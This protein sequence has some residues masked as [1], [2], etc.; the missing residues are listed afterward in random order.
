IKNLRYQLGLAWTNDIPEY[1]ALYNS[2]QNGLWDFEEPFTDNNDNGV[3]DDGEPYTD[4]YSI[5]NERLE[6]KF[7][8]AFTIPALFNYKFSDR[9]STDLKYEFQRLKKGTSYRNTLL[10]DEVFFDLDGDGVWDA[11]E[12]FTDLDGDGVWDAA[13][14][15]WYDWWLNGWI[16]DDQLSNYDTNGNGVYDL[17]EDFTDSDG[18]GIW[19]AAEEFIDLDGDG[20]WDD[21]EEFDDLN[22]DGIWTGKG[23]YIDSSRSNFYVL[24]KKDDHKKT[25]DFQYNHMITIGV[26]RS[27]YWSVSLTIESSSTYEY[28]P[29]LASIT[30][31][32]EKFMGNFMDIDNKWIA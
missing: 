27:P 26:G 20:I 12:Q 28:G 2:G 18:D 32:L 29:Q 24:N 25:K 4:Y 5:V 13:E 15:N 7:Q 16:P 19:D 3:W 22:N 11:A 6:N 9:W 30:N 23:V 1:H 21:G 17:G 14:Q 10:S 8:N 31:P